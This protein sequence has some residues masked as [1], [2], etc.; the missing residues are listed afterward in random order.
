[1]TEKE[2]RIGIFL[3]LT[4]PFA[5]MMEFIQSLQ[6]TDKLF[7]L[8]EENEKQYLMMITKDF[9]ETRQLAKQVSHK[10]GIGLMSAASDL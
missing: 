5:N 7:Y 2:K 6:N 3:W 9:V 8:V 10:R 1:M 4:T